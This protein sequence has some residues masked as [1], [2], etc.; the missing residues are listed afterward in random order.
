[1]DGLN[2]NGLP[3]RVSNPGSSP[4]FDAL[5]GERPDSDHQTL[6]KRQSLIP[7]IR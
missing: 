5:S 4:H 1:M 7:L 6:A 3:F 2:G